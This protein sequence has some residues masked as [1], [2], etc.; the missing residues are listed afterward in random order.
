[1]PH[2]DHTRSQPD[3]TRGPEDDQ[4][5]LNPHFL[6]RENHEMAGPHPELTAPTAYGI[7]AINR[8][9][10]ELADDTLSRFP[11]FRRDHGW[12][13]T[14]PILTFMRQSH[15]SASMVAGPDNWYVLKKSVPCTRWN[16][17]IGVTDPARLDEDTPPEPTDRFPGTY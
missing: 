4:N 17:L 10:N 11:L 1:M 9:Y 12:S 16:T 5:D 7:K 6:A 8:R 15:A 13:R 2:A 3:Q 14:R